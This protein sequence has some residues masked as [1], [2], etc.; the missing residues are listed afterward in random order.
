MLA[1][2]LIHSLT[3][4][5]FIFSL[6][7]IPHLLFAH[8]TVHWPRKWDL[9]FFAP[10]PQLL[11][12]NRPIYLHVYVCVCVWVRIYVYI[13]L[14][15]GCDVYGLFTHSSLKAKKKKIVVNKWTNER[16]TINKNVNNDPMIGHLCWLPITLLINFTI[17]P[18]FIDNNYSNHK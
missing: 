14:R 10:F 15:I 13:Q 1:R 6:L 11:P 16:T 2:S 12:L 9:Q 4:S 3:R 8:L 5:R 7:S 17:H 18:L